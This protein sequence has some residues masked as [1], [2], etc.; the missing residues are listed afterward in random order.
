MQA[1]IKFY[2]VKDPYGYM[3]N[4]SPHPIWHQGKKYITSEHYYQCQKFVD[5]E[6]YEKVRLVPD[7]HKIKDVANHKEAP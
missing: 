4:F 5:M 2:R 3:S 6:Y 7:V 1:E